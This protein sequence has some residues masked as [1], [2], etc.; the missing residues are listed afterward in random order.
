[1]VSTF[2]P[3]GE[4]TRVWRVCHPIGPSA[5]LRMDVFSDRKYDFSRGT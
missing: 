5:I 3:R 4:K 1:M 2:S